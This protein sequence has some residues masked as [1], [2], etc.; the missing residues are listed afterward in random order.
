MKV[1]S[2]RKQKIFLSNFCTLIFSVTSLFPTISICSETSNFSVTLSQSLELDITKYS[3]NGSDLLLFVYP[4]SGKGIT[5]HHETMAQELVKANFEVWIADITD[6]LFLPHSS[7]TMRKMTG[8]YLAEL[9]VKAHEKTGKNIYIAGNS[10]AAIPVLRAAYRWQKGKPKTSYLKSAVLFTPKLYKTLPPLGQ[11]PNYLP[12]VSATSIPLIIFQGSKHGNKWQLPNLLEALRASNPDIFVEMMPDIGSL[13]VGKT[14]AEKQKL[15]FNILP[16]KLRYSSKLQTE[17]TPLRVAKEISFDTITNTGIDNRLKNYTGQ[18]KPL[19]IS[20][21]DYAGNQFELKE[22][23]GKVTVVNFW[24]TWC[25]PCVK[26]IPSLNRLKALMKNKPFELIS[27]NFQE[28]PDAIREFQ[29]MVKVKFPV[30]MDSD[31]KIANSWKVVAF[32]S[33]FIIASDGNI[34]Y[35]VNAGIEWDT[36]EVIEIINSLF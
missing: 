7:S 13:F 33:T 5:R 24:A 31:G 20:L 17:S 30:L 19:P 18:V 26:E 34:H 2:C 6:A 10:Y 15:F 16:A 14:L 4:T 35:G 28:K 27:I 11:D 3:A 9:V 8:E 25:S 23:K 29:K 32:P 12:I 22:Y 1:M 36:P 21:L